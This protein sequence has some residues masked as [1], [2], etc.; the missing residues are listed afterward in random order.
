MHENVEL[1][2]I[3]TQARKVE[4][5]LWADPHPVPP[6]VYRKARRGQALDLSD[7]VP[8][9]TDK[10]SNAVTRGPP[11]LGT[12]ESVPAMSPY[13]IIGNRKSHFYHRPDC[14]NYSQVAPKNRVAFNCAAAAEAAGY[15]VAGNCP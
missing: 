5:R 8:M 9:D 1:E 10:E 7:L 12:E 2:I 6:W 4:R 3:E 13:P 14:P 15:R 11:L